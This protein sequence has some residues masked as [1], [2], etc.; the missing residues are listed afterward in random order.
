M[1]AKDIMAAPSEST[2]PQLVQYMYYDSSKTQRGPAMGA[3]MKY[4]FEKGIINEDSFIWTTGM[5][6]WKPLKDSPV[7]AYHI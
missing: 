1:D 7:S 6:E 5:P 3:E 4:L 2:P